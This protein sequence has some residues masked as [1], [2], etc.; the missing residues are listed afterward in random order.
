MALAKGLG[1]LAEILKRKDKAVELWMQWRSIHQEAF[2]YCA[3]NRNTITTFSEGSHKTRRIFDSTAILANQQFSN[4]IEGLMYPSWQQWMEYAAGDEVPEEDREKADT[5]LKEQTDIFFSH[6][7]HSNFSTELS[8]ALLDLGIG[9]GAMLV[10][11]GEFNKGEALR[12]S[13]VPLAE[14]YPE[15]PAAGAIETV[16]RKQ[17]IRP[18]NI[19]RLWPEAELSDELAKMAKDDPTSEVDIWNSFIFNPTDGLYH[20]VVIHEDSKH[21]V[22]TQ[23]FATKRLIVFRSH[24]TPGEVFGRGPGIQTLE[25]V[26]TLNKVREFVLQNAALQISGTYTA[27][28]DGVFNPH[29]FRVVPGAVN[30]VGTNST[31]NPSLQALPKSGDIGLGGIIIEDLAN[32]IKKAFF[33]DPLGEIT[34][35]VRTAIE[36]MMRQQEMLKTSGAS[37]GRLNSEFTEPLVAAVTEILMT[38]GKIEPI[39]VDGREVTIRQTSP[40][41]KAEGAENF[42]NTSLWLST[43]AGLLPPEII[44]ASVKVEDLPRSFA[45]DLGVDISLVRTD[46]EREQ[47]A[48]K[49]QDAAEAQIDQGAPQDGI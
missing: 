18:I 46:E 19:K 24:L 38:L 36:Q 14:L 23:S 42:Q 15:K 6:L 2:E 13:N 4:R 35:P 17:K 27:V 41:S 28:D 20:Q 31:Q 49:V 32:N 26:R 33:A 30:A 45:E 12:F 8:P 3:P 7:N 37:F 16:F 40:L 10:E 29:T 44:G 39:R 9:T 5:L 1:D 25:D 11:A 47:L 21:V 34:D 22:F 48:Q 43:L